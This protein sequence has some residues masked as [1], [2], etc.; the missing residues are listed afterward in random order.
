MPVGQRVLT[1][2]SVQKHL[3]NLDARHFALA[4]LD[5]EKE[6]PSSLIEN[7]EDEFTSRPAAVLV[8]FIVSGDK[9]D[10]LIVM[11][12]TMEV[13]HHKGQVSFPGGMTELGDKD[14]AATALRKPTK[15]LE[16]LH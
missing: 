7:L 6:L 5:Q 3:N 11:T 1:V 15:K 10:S 12:R 2:E 4:E 8:P 14:S 16:L 13:S 9:I